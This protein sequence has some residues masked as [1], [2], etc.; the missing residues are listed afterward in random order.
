M[1]RSLLAG[2]I[3]TAPILAALR[4][5]PVVNVPRTSSAVTVDGR[6]N[7][8]EW[9]GASSERLA[10]GSTLR[11][12]HDGQYLYIAVAPARQGFVSVCATRNDSVRVLHASA[13]LGAVSYAH[14]SSGWNSRDTA[15]TYGMRAPDT[16]EAVRL[17]RRAYLE[18]HGWVSS[19]VT[20]TDGRSTEMQISLS[21]FDANPRLALAWYSFQPGT[22]IPIVGWPGSLRQNEGCLASD[23]VRGYVPRGLAFSLAEW[24]ELRLDLAVQELKVRSNS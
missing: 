8:G 7:D 18:R 14:S 16:T 21:E 23:L 11:M 17:E 13:A 22:E 15:F 10:D 4:E 6:I 2:L 20:M 9:R 3:L 24:A 1:E 5:G 12:Q 19:T